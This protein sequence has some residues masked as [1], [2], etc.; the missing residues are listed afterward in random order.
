[1]PANY[2]IYSLFAAIIFVLVSC[3]TSGRPAEEEGLAILIN[4]QHA[5]QGISWFSDKS[6]EIA[7]GSQGALDVVCHFEI[8][9]NKIL[10]EVELYNTGKEVL[11]LQQ[12]LLLSQA[13]DPELP[14]CSENC[15]WTW[16]SMKMESGTGLELKLGASSLRLLPKEKVQ[17]YIRP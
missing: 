11:D 6:E 15:W 5:D 2:H 3:Q 12:L 4:G 1:M 16:S 7:I 8:H 13:G 17:V 14:S 10:K 9:G